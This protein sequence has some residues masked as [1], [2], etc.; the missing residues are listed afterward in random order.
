M[1]EQSLKGMGNE[2]KL[3]VCHYVSLFP[4]GLALFLFLSISHARVN[5]PFS[6]AMVP[7]ILF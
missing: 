7:F 1:V 6:G 5:L 2:M 4:F 3:L